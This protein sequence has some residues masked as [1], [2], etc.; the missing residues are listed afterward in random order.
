MTYKYFSDD[1]IVGLEPALVEKLDAARGFAGI[2]F[3]ITSGK[4]SEDDNES[5]QGAGDSSH[6]RG[7]AVDLAC[8]GS[9]TRF[10]MLPALLLAGFNRIGIYDGHIHVDID[11]TKDDDVMWIGLSH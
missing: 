4:R 3:I 6:L 9:R 1:E 7:L 8:R 11:D 5:C 10:Y 2:P